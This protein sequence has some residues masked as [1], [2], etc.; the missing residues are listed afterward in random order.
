MMISH[1]EA[2][3]IVLSTSFRTYTEEI[4]IDKSIGR[5]LAHDVFSDIN[6]PPFDK[7]MVDGY[8]CLKSDIDNEM[9]IDSIVGAGDGTKYIVDK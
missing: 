5:I 7:C 2:L 1:S 8:A 4:E 9:I 3:D 6:M